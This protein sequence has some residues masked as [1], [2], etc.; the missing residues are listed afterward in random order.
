[1]NPRAAQAARAARLE[2]WIFGGWLWTALPSALR[3]AEQGRRLLRAAYAELQQRAD[4]DF[5]LP[6]QRQRLLIN[7]AWLHYE[8]RDRAPGAPEPAD[9]AAPPADTAAP[10]AGHPAPADRH[11]IPRP[12]S[13]SISSEP[14]ASEPAALD[15]ESLRS[16][17]C[18]L[19]PGCDFARRAYADAADSTPPS[20]N[21][22]APNP[23]P[24]VLP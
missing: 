14:A 4:A 5:P 15:P 10:P 3:R 21:G 17:I 22:F 24:E 9:T 19:D 20:D 2:A 1:M 6:G 16:R 7:A 8:S 23:S 13:P 12:D 11:A 18:R